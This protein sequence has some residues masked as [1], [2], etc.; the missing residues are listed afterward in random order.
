MYHW[1]CLLASVVALTAG[2]LPHVDLHVHLH[3]DGKSPKHME[4][5]DAVALSKKLGVRFGVLGE[6]GCAGEIHNDATLAE[7]IKEFDG[8]P[9]WRGLQVYGFEWRKCLSSANLDRLDYVAADALV[10]PDGKG[11]HVWLWLPDVN[12]PDAEKFMDQYVDFNVQVLSQRI[13]IWANPTFL[14]KSMQARYDALW[15]PQRMDRVI[16]AAVKNG[17]AIEI[18]AQYK[19][20]SATFLRRA[21]AA[22]AK[23]S[24]GSNG[25]VKGIG[26]IDYCLRMANEIGLTE[27]DI[28]VPSRALAW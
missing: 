13:Q 14:P 8:V 18:N 1:I 3:E 10:F 12:F 6:G 4:P 15:T 2:E 17:I 16:Q 24:F 19:I 21:K 20:P 22:G 25:H 28:Y 23:F 26:E 9:V 27:R 7:F 11:K 5:A